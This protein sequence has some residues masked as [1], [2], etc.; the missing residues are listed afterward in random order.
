MEL[1]YNWEDGKTF[2]RKIVGLALLPAE[3]IRG[4][5]NWLRANATAEILE[6]FQDYLNYYETWWLDTVKPEHFSV[7]SLTIRTNN[8]IE[9]YHRALQQEIPRHPTIWLF[10]SK[11]PRSNDILYSMLL[12]PIE[13][14][15]KIESDHFINCRTF[16]ESTIHSYE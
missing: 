7:F 3:N 2:F 5:Y 8:A 16:S 11:K 6:K 9:A 14:L 12:I 10:T 15:K 4:A 1:L 13:F